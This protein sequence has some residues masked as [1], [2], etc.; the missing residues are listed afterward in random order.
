M[1]FYWDENPCTLKEVL[2]EL[3]KQYV[4]NF[5]HVGMNDWNTTIKPNV[6]L[7][8]DAIGSLKD[9]KHLEFK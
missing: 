4:D 8:L 1:K 3:S 7:L 2:E 6:Q 5:Q 9:D